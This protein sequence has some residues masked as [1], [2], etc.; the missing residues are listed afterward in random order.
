MILIN[1]LSWREESRKRQKITLSAVGGVVILFGIMC[2]TVVHMLVASKINFEN[3][4]IGFL[5]SN[6]EKINI[7]MIA[8]S[9]EKENRENLIEKMNTLQHIQMQRFMVVRIFNEIV[10]VIPEG[11]QLTKMALTGNEL[12]LEGVADS[13]TKIPELMNNINRSKWLV[14]PILNEINKNEAQDSKWVFTL[15]LTAVMDQVNEGALAASDIKSKDA[16]KVV[17]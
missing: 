13:N 15:K 8:L 3:K 10:N 5:Q 12:L 11:V 2:I 14:S 17:K 6:F 4:R 7:K 9:N 1:F 16:Q